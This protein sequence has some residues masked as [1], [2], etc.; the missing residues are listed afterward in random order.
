MDIKTYSEKILKKY[1]NFQ[2]ENG[3]QGRHAVQQRYKLQIQ[4]KS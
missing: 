4:L 2:K 3:E 1:K